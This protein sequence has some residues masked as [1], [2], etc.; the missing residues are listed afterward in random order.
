M[1]GP[2]HQKPAAAA[3]KAAPKATPKTATAPAPPAPT[4]EPAQPYTPPS[5]KHTPPALDPVVVFRISAWILGLVALVGLVSATLPQT[6]VNDQF[7][8]GV[9]LQFTWGHNVLHILLAAAAALFGYAVLEPRLVKSMAI[10]VGS[11]YLVLGVLGFFWLNW[12]ADE[13]VLALT[14]TL[15]AVHLLLGAWALAAGLLSDA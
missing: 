4:P 14:P 1:A 5:K 6:K 13:T 8:G 15:N 3:P 11:V 10:V 7:L 12:P 9:G 2:T